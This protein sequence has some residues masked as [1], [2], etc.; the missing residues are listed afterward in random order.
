MVDVCHVSHFVL[1]EEERKSSICNYPLRGAECACD[2]CQF[3]HQNLMETKVGCPTILLKVASPKGVINIE[4]ID[5]VV[6][7]GI[8]ALLRRLALA[9]D[10]L[11]GSTLL[12][13]SFWIGYPFFRAVFN[14]WM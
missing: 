10:W 2:L 6:A 1:G 13:G 3:R 8:F 11:F 9:S 7:L 4:V 5:V 14:S 12:S